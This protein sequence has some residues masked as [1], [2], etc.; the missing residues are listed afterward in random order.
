MFGRSVS[1]PLMT[2]RTMIQM[3]RMLKMKIMMRKKRMNTM[4]K[5]MM[6]K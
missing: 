2:R 4:M 3:L 6:R 5:R 1:G